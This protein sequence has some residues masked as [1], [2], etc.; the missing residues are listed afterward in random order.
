M[1]LEDAITV[2]RPIKNV[3]IFLEAS[4]VPRFHL[5]GRSILKL[6]YAETELMYIGDSLQGKFCKAFK[7]KLVHFVDNTSLM[8]EYAIAAFLDP[9]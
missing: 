9:R 5:T 7:E 6:L 2:L 8:L 1:D 3:Q 4:D